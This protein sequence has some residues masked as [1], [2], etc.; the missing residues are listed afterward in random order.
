M[1]AV[2]HFISLIGLNLC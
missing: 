2:T 1:T